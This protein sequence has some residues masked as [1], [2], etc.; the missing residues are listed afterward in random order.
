MEHKLILLSE[1]NR[2]LYRKTIIFYTC[3]KPLHHAIFFKENV[4]RKKKRKIQTYLIHIVKLLENLQPPSK[5]AKDFSLG[6]F[7]EKFLNTRI[8]Y[9]NY[10]NVLTVLFF[11]IKF[12]SLS[13]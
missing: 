11:F 5:S 1:I 3:N 10:L 4:L 13:M 6:L 7:Q 8:N 12:Y 2:N 9:L